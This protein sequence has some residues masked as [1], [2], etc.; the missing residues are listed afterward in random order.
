[1]RAV[2]IT[3]FG[4]PEVLRLGERPAPV[5][6]AAELLIRV[7]ASGINRPDVLQR[8]GNYPVPAG[9]SDIPG[10]E[11]AGEIVGYSV[12]M[13]AAG[14]AHLLNLS[15]AAAWQRRGFGRDMLEFVRGLARDHAAGKAYLEVRPSN[16]AGRCLYVSAGF[17]EIATRRGYYPAHDGREDA[18]VMEL[19]FK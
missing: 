16:I 14:E 13:I 18:V 19:A 11:V 7:G 2:E 3:S 4:A 1:M 8:T 9:A 12:V 15:I 6:G 17:S 5:P 10:L